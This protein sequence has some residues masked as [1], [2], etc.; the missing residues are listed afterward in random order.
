MADTI[1]TIAIDLTLNSK[2][3]KTK[4]NEVDKLSDKAGKNI[5]DSLDK[6]G[7][8]GSDGMAMIEKSARKTGEALVKVAALATAAATA[9]VGFALKSAADFQQ[10]RIGIENMLGSADAARDTLTEISQIA[11]TTPFE[12]AELAESVKQLLAFGF[13]AEDAVSTMKNLGDVSAAIGAPIGDLS[14]LMGTLKTQGRAFTI[15]I[16]QFAQRG[17]P[18]YEYLA[19]TLGKSEQ[20]ITS[21]IEE[22]KIGFPEVENAFKAMTSEGG[23]FY[24]TMDK[25]SDSFNGRISTLKDNIAIFA[26]RLVGLTEAGD[27]VKGG[28]FDKLTTGL[29]DLN[30]WIDNNQETID[31]WATDF[32]NFVTDMWNK[33]ND[34]ITWVGKNKD[35]LAPLIAG[36]VALKVALDLTVAFK[37]VSGAFTVLSATVGTPLVMPAIVVAAAITALTMVINKMLEAKAAVKSAGEAIKNNISVNDQILKASKEAYEAGDTAKADKLFKIAES[38]YQNAA[39]Q[40][41]SLT[42]NPYT[43]ASILGFSNGG[44]TGLGASNE[45]AGV[46]HRG[47]YVLPQNMV[48][49][50]T[51]TPKMGGIENHIGTINISSDVDGEKWLQRLTQNQEII[52]KGLV[53]TQRYA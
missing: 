34:F 14:Y 33:I 8:K 43:P 10:T 29:Q 45:V 25:Q 48:D 51:G 7:K 39:Q 5:G 37:T 17:I 41:N 3:F 53:P 46:V 16:R 4:L 18:I 12:F 42:V 26:R 35:W 19:K 9:A 21:M 22:G 47:E 52:S 15:D 32:T 24:G 2:D 40:L 36:L 1:K 44:F 20:A 50:S 31:Q 11:K 6:G 13:N 27:V 49:Q 38:G 28:L 30:Y 23:K